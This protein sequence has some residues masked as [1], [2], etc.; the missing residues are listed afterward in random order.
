MHQQTLADA[1]AALLQHS[2]TLAEAIEQTLRATD[3]VLG[4]LAERMRVAAAGDSTSYQKTIADRDTYSLLKEKASELPQI[5]A[6]ALIGTDGKLLNISRTWPAPD[7]NFADR[8]DFPLARAMPHLSS[9]FITLQH[10]R[11]TKE[12]LLVLTRATRTE[13]GA[14]LGE[15]DAAIKLGYF[16]TLFLSSS[17]GDGYAVSLMRQDGTLLARYPTAGG[18]GSHFSASVLRTLTGSRS[19]VSRAV[20]PVDG[21]RRIAAA[22]KLQDYPLIVVATRNEDLIFAALHTTV[23][24]TIGASGIAIL[25]VIA[26][27]LAAGAWLRQQDQLYLSEERRRF[28]VE[29]AAIG[30]WDYCHTTGETLWSDQLRMIIGVGPATAPTKSNFMNQVFP[31]DRHIIEENETTDSSRPHDFR[32]E[33][34]VLSERNKIRWVSASGRKEFDSDGRMLRLRGAVQ[35]ITARKEAEMERDELRRRLLQAHEFE[36]LRLAHELHDEAGQRVAAILMRLE[37]LSASVGESGRVHIQ[38]LRGQL[39]RMG[40]ALHHVAWE[41]RPPSI[42]ELGLKEA[43]SNYIAAWSEQAGI[44]GDFY[45]S[46]ALTGFTE[47]IRTSCYRI[48]QEALT[49]VARHAKTARAVSVIIDQLGDELRLTIEDDGAGFVHT[50]GDAHG[51]KH[52][53]GLGLPGIRERLAL[54]GGE[55]TIETPEGNGTTLYIRMPLRKEM[56]SA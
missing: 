25:A 28:A 42:D 5:D 34:R 33:F 51:G 43:L 35:D 27:A 2:L 40:R 22:Y 36:R 29:A 54:I 8:E 1:Q 55:L 50:T 41:L 15:V 26:A 56:L 6:L 31:N 16:E 11:I 48:V 9:S 30:T 3:L 17:L 10:S 47:E 12:W 46:A 44:A 52:D 14:F 18:I 7:L 19:G 37:R 53:R 20:S 39:Q 49:N 4:N 13:Q 23:M 38:S 21:E 45:C 24:I 32:I